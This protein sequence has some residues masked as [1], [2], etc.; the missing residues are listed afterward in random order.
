[1]NDIKAP[2]AFRT[3]S[4]VSEML[5]VPQHVLRF[6]ET[7]FEQVVP[8]KRGGNRRYYRPE[9]V[10]LLSQIRDLLYRDGYTTKGVQRLFDEGQLPRETAKDDDVVVKDDDAVV[11]DVPQNTSHPQSAVNVEETGGSSG[12]DSG[13]LPEET[14]S[15]L[16]GLRDKLSRLAER[17]ATVA[18]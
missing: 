12:Y 11:H 13:H 8:L 18:N 7:K 3:I 10:A 16:V 4:E 2:D 5:D 17:L 9:H 14:Y 6:W 15:K 1:M